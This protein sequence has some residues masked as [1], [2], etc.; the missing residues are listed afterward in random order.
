MGV[1]VHICQDPQKKIQPTSFRLSISTQATRIQ[2]QTGA[3]KLS[4]VVAAVVALAAHVQGEQIGG[5]KR[6]DTKVC[7][8]FLFFI[9]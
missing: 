5:L 1:G 8:F 7:T 3:M 6:P 2:Y 4:M 9:K